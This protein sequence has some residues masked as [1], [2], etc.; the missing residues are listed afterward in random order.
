M[1]P[2]AMGLRRETDGDLSANVCHRHSGG[3]E[4]SATVDRGVKGPKGKKGRTNAVFLDSHVE[5]RRDA[6]KRLFTLEPD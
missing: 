5:L 1:L 6:P 3:N 2:R 4:R